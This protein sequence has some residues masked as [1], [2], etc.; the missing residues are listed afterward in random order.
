MAYDAAGNQA[1]AGV[2]QWGRS[3][4]DGKLI[5]RSMGTSDGDITVIL[6]HWDTDRQAAVQALTPMVYSELHRIAASYLRRQRS[7]HT[8]QPTALINEAYMRM[9]KQESASIRD[10]SH[11][12]TLAARM[13]RQILVDAA[14]AHLA[15]KRGSGNKVQL[16]EK[17]EIAGPESNQ[18]TDFL[19]IH[20][21]L[22]KLQTHNARLAQ[23]VE[24]RYFGGLQL[25]EIAEALELSV[26][27]VKRDLALGEAWLRRALTA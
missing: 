24:L 21:A 14:R 20:E 13:M 1:A 26:A 15:E 9:V 25:D 16:D 2:T 18:G 23:S 8:L 10:R 6:Q 11:F 22:D 5:E 27:T 12:F 4:S 17:L 7:D 19:A 3:G